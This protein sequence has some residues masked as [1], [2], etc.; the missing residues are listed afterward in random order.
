[1]HA[2]NC[3][4]IASNSYSDACISLSAQE[5]PTAYVLTYI[6]MDKIVGNCPALQMDDCSHSVT[7]KITS[8]PLYTICSNTRKEYM[9]QNF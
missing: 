7:L 1:M 4:I 6:I 3:N 5:I 8:R 2:M 9:S